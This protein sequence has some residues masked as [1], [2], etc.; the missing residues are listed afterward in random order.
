MVNSNWVNLF[1]YCDIGIIKS[2]IEDKKE[3]NKVMVL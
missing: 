1:D 3:I 2:F